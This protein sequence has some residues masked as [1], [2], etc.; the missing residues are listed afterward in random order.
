[1]ELRTRVQL[2]AL[3]MELMK[4]TESASGDTE[5]AS[6]DTEPA[7]G[8]T[9]SASS[10]TE[11]A[12]GAGETLSPQT[13]A[14]ATTPTSGEISDSHLRR[15]LLRKL[16]QQNAVDLIRYTAHPPFC[17]QSVIIWR[18]SQGNP[19]VGGVKAKTG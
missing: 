15:L 16:R 14:A 2:H 17:C 18:S 12:S 1:M 4:H 19:S 3:A 9:E 11:S 5:P 7:S 10:D 6:G 13:A 8:D